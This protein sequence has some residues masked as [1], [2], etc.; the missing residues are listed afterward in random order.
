MKI[1]K[2]YVTNLYLTESRK[3]IVLAYLWQNPQATPKEIMKALEDM[4]LKISRH[5][6]YK[7]IKEFKSKGYIQDITLEARYRMVVAS[8]RR[9]SGRDGKTG[10]HNGR[11]YGRLA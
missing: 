4:G 5:S 7:T 2:R 6:L 1:P 8:N 10:T 3:G 9:S 11:I